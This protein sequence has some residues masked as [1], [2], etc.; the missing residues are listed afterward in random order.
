MIGAR[1]EMEGTTMNRAEQSKQMNQIIARCWSDEGFKRKLMADPVATLN[2]EG[3]EV[4]AGMSVKVLENT[5]TVSYLVIPAQPAELSDQ[6]LRNV[7]GGAVWWT[8]K[9]P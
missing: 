7:A 4:P 2:A 8:D 5:D 6:D 1:P 9:N 3:M